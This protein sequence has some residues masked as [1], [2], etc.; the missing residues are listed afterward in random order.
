MSAWRCGR[1]SPVATITPCTTRTARSISPD[2][3]ARR[4]SRSGG[5]M[6]A[7]P[8]L[9]VPRTAGTSPRSRGIAISCMRR[10]RR[11]ASMRRRIWR[12]RACSRGNL[13]ACRPLDPRRRRRAVC[14]R[15]GDGRCGGAPQRARAPQRIRVAAPP[16]ADAYIVARG[17][18]RTI[19]P[20]IRGSPT[21]AGT[22]SSRCRASAS[23]PAGS[24][25][26]R[27]PAA[28]G[29]RRFGR[30]AAESVQRQRRTARVQCR[31]RVALV[32]DRGAGLRRRDA[33]HG[34]ARPPGRPPRL[35][36][37][38][39]RDCRGLSCGHTLR[40][41]DGRGR[42]DRA[43]AP[44]VQ[45][46]WM[47]ARVGDRVITPRTGK[48][49]EVQALWINALAIAGRRDPRW[50]DVRAPRDRVLPRPILERGARVS[51]RRRRCRSRARHVRRLA[52]AQ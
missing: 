45:L 43:G 20:A 11:A 27:H 49:V 32:R 48:P 12:A 5:P 50:L 21:G 8:R 46:T 47:D 34:D 4:A 17:P 36:A 13:H 31:R 35:R 9:R 38:H 37:R 6:P 15:A 44:G 2:A 14:R 24:I 22:P 18:G 51:A 28:V 52:A 10:K 23:R 3:H 26:P 16:A 29:G 7:C 40:H 1:S 39:P 30:H 19:V 25:R 41:P 42:P 33:A